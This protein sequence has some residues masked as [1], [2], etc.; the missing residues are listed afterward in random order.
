MQDINTIPENC[1]YFLFR[2]NIQPMW[3]DT[4]NK[5]GCELRVSILR[6]MNA[7]NMWK[8]SVFRMPYIAMTFLAFGGCG[9]SAE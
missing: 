2:E 3:E 4:A 9:V 1:D 5:G 7:A 6:N 8:I